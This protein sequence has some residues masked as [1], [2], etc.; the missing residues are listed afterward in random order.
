MIVPIEMKHGAVSNPIFLRSGIVFAASEANRRF[1]SGL[2]ED[3]K[4][5]L[6]GVMFTIS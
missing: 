6:E 2:I 5:N 1:P 4:V 3:L